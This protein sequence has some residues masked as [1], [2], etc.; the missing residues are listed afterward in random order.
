MR[1]EVTATDTPAV[2]ESW[3]TVSSTAF[4][5]GNIFN[6]EGTNAELPVHTVVLDAFQIGAT[7]VTFATWEIVRNWATAHG[8]A[9]TTE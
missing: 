1:F 6:G 5:M 8:Y 7:E 3:I 9:F 2:N 4:N